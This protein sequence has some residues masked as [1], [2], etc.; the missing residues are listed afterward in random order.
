MR[1]IISDKLSDKYRNY[2]VMKSCKEVLE[3]ISKDPDFASGVEMMIIHHTPEQ[4]LQTG[5]GLSKFVKSGI[6]QIHYVSNP[7]DPGVQMAVNGVGGKCIGDEFYF[8]DEEELDAL[9][10][11]IDQQTFSLAQNNVYI[12]RDFLQ[13]FTRGDEHI[14]APV[15]LDQVNSA[16]VELANTTQ[17]QELQI[18]QMGNS[19]I[20]TFEQASK[21]LSSLQEQIKRSAKQIE[22]L[23]EA[24][25]NAAS[26]RRSS[27]GTTGNFYPSVA[28]VG[29]TKVLCVRELSHCRY[30]TS[31]MMAYRHHLAYVKNKRAKLVVAY[32]G[33]PGVAKKYGDF[34]TIT[35][36]SY[37]ND[38]LY[39][40]DLV[41]TNIPR[42]D[43]MLHLMKTGEQ[44]V[45]VLD[46]LYGD[47]P[48][49]KSKVTLINA[50]SGTSDLQR[51]GVRAKDCIFS[52]VKHPECLFALSHIR[53]F[54]ADSDGRY[55]A[56]TSAFEK[57]FEMLDTMLGI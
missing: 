34:T 24:H 10:A 23:Q 12:L 13:A 19:A 29:T 5:M 41:A 2:K 44:V 32:A 54:P 35:Q 31:F 45:L 57:Q 28:Y 18:A 38:D 37:Q 11:D 49:M 16:L 40:A 46:R 8:E 47:Q 56:Y 6:K 3:A 4:S 36:E 1:I 21:I 39:S 7:L 22:D 52:T 55:A 25:D 33:G 14:N 50:V 15:Y 30:L 53:A 51:Y 26:Q 20:E 43:I 9:L 17:R 48:I 27:F 42:R